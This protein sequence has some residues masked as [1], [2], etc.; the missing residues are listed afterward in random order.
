[1]PWEKYLVVIGRVPIINVFD[2]GKGDLLKIFH[3]SR[4]KHARIKK[5]ITDNLTFFLLCKKTYSDGHRERVRG[6]TRQ[7]SRT[8]AYR[9]ASFFLL[10]IFHQV[11]ISS[12]KTLSL[13]SPLLSPFWYK[14]LV[15]EEP[16]L[17]RA[18]HFP[19]APLQSGYLP[20]RPLQ[21]HP[22]WL[23][24]PLFRQLPA[25]SFLT[26]HL[27]GGFRAYLFYFLSKGFLI[28]LGLWVVR[29]CLRH[30]RCRAREKAEGG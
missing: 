7:P 15:K 18:M 10:W 1:M 3:Y 14:L 23:L 29:L 25:S 21:R 27:W 12:F 5:I 22:T 17:L 8:G 9:R 24:F 11:F 26:E 6:E 16:L 4:N 13:S 19:L 30:R 20:I 28:L 2:D